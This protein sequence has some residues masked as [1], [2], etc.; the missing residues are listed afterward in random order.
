MISKNP[1]SPENLSCMSMF[2]SR[3]LKS[4]S[5]LFVNYLNVLDWSSLRMLEV[6]E[7]STSTLEQSKPRPFQLLCDSFNFWSTSSIHAHILQDPQDDNLLFN[8]QWATQS[9][10]TKHIPPVQISRWLSV[11]NK[12]YSKSQLLSASVTDTIHVLITQTQPCICHHLFGMI[13][14]KLLFKECVYIDMEYIQVCYDAIQYYPAFFSLLRIAACCHKTKSRW[15][16]R[17]GT[18]AWYSCS[19]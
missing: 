8:T 16:W 19:Q 1:L 14:L 9:W 2:G 6:L 12:T 13:K 3:H 4:G 7:K 10:K 15:S 5:Q 18:Q 11:L 17:R